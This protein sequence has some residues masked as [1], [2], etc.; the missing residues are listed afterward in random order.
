MTTALAWFCPGRRP[1]SLLTLGKVESPRDPQNHGGQNPRPCFPNQGSA[2]W[3]FCTL[4]YHPGQSPTNS[5][6][7]PQ[8]KAL[9]HHLGMSLPFE[10]VLHQLGQSSITWGNPPS[11]GQCSTT[12]GSPPPPGIVLHHSGQSCTIWGNPPP[13]GK[14]STTR[15]TP[16]TSRALLH[17]SIHPEQSST[18]RGTTPLPG[19]VPCHPGQPSTTGDPPP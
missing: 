11:P 12:P 14:S 4:S 7:P 15:D 13:T 3:A 19:A 8:L 2:G 9:L 5:G 16:P 17:S 18:T 10:T 1:R 6:N